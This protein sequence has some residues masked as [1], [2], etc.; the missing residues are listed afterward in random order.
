MCHVLIIEDEPLVALNLED[1]LTT[2]G[3][4]SF[5]IVNSESDAIKAADARVPAI[6]TSDV[7]LV[8]GTGPCAVR[9]IH[10]RLGDIPVI[11]ITG[12]PED[13]IPCDPPGVIL[14]KPLDGP[15]ITAAF[16]RFKLV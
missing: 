14:G 16:N 13:C 3:A 10:Q 7:R 8:E 11:F 6:I 1:L 2:A 4:T 12:T 15:A 9:A 5:D